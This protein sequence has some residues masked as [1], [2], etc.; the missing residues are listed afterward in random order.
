MEVEVNSL[1]NKIKRPRSV[2]IISLFYWLNALVLGAIGVIAV[3][4]LAGPYLGGTLP[5][6]QIS[7]E[8]PSILLWGS[9]FVGIIALA[10]FSAVVGWGLW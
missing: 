5:L 8:M 1:N 4:L 6:S 9:L 10:I 3:L 2:T 7:E